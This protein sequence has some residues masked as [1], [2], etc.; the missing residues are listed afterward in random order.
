MS[1][2]LQDDPM[3][4]NLDKW[5]QVGSQFIKSPSYKEQLDTCHEVYILVEEANN[6]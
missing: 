3:E 2:I 6:K 1:N 4:S 5:P